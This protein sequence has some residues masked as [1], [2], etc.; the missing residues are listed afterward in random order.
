MKILIACEFSGTVRDA[1][2]ANGHDA[3]SCDLL[4]SD[5]P[6]AHY[7]GDVL[8]ILNDGFDMMVAH[9][10]CT[11]LCCSG[12]FRNKTSLERSEKTLLALEF[13]NNLLTADIEK[14]CLENPVGRI[15]TAIRRPDQYIQPYNFGE[16]ASKKTGLWLKNLPKLTPSQ[17]CAPR[18]ANNLHRWSNQ[19][20]S[21]QNRLPPSKDRWKLR[22]QTYQ[23]IADAMACQ[24]G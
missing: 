7:Q 17:Y 23:G 15:N 3:I 22:S 11:Y 19:T 20:D 24:W 5:L 18:M 14:I 13:V 12:L 21:G 6:G 10:P 9:P 8:D 4:P 16:D 2:A 1:F